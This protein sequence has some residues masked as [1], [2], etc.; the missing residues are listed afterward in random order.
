MIMKNKILIVALAA[1]SLLLFGCKRRAADGARSYSQNDPC[2]LALVPHIGTDP[3]DQEIIRLQREAKDSKQQGPIV[4]RLGWAFVQK[5]RSSYDSGY[6]KLAETCAT[7]LQSRDETRL[8]GLLLGGHVLQSLHRF[9]E[10]ELA[11]KE[12]VSSRGLPFDYGLLGDALMEQG[13]LAEAT[14]AYQTMVDL[15]PGPQSYSRAAHIR[16]LKGDLAGSIELMRMAANA[17]TSQD[18]ESAAW[19]YARL[20][21]YELQAGQIRSALQA[22]EAAEFFLPDYAPSLLVRGRVLLAEGKSVEAIAP[23]QQAAGLIALPEY[24]WA[25]ADALRAAGRDSEA[26]QVEGDL[27]RDGPASDPRTFAL[28][29]AT[30][31]DRI[32]QAVDLADKE[33]EVRNDV[34][35]LDAYAW[36]LAAAD[37]KAEAASVIARALAEGT[38]DARLFYH[39]GVIA[40]MNGDK[41]EARRW[42]SRAA[43]VRQMLLPSERTDL[44]K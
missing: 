37:R 16:W 44:M 24:Q 34:F 28:Y 17:G 21:N 15:K 25:L 27:L 2:E 33:L 1:A 30:R 9:K 10:A 14:A 41:V 38:A 31:R 26:I 20:A 11:A 42:L 39:A 23:L 35:T 6:Y 12:L 13:R 8:E 4:E 18:R 22:C 29:L 43:S 40:L 5:A 32:E 3:L 7:C 19:A 36:S